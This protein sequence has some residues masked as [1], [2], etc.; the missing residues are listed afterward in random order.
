MT[1]T[2]DVDDFFVDD[3]KATVHSDPKRMED[4]GLPTPTAE[5]VRNWTPEG[6]GRGGDGPPGGG[7]ESPPA[8]PPEGW[9]EAAAV[10]EMPR[11]APP[12]VE[13]PPPPHCEFS[14]TAC[15]AGYAPYDAPPTPGW[16]FPPQPPQPQFIPHIVYAYPYA[17]AF[18][19]AGGPAGD[20]Y[21]MLCSAPYPAGEARKRRWEEEPGEGQGE[22]KRGRKQKMPRASLIA[23]VETCVQYDQTAVIKTGEVYQVLC[24]QRLLTFVNYFR[25]GCDVESIDLSYLKENFQP[26]KKLF[27]KISPT[28]FKV[29]PKCSNWQMK[30]NL[31]AKQTHHLTQILSEIYKN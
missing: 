13:L 21:R 17:F 15:P 1:D 9:R 4:W 7:C 22:A 25:E 6:E 10:Q 29:H 11:A 19:Q 3:W 18:P 28:T 23:A 30:T 2:F 12:P 31:T 5:T 8:E 24:W 26:S 27:V 16:F 14:L 20:P